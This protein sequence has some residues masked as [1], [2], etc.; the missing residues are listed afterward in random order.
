MPAPGATHYVAPEKYAQMAWVIGLGHADDDA[1]RRE[2]LFARVDGLLDEVGI[3]LSLADAG[4]GR[5]AFDAALPDLARAAFDDPS[6]RTN[7][8]IPLVA[9]LTALLRAGYDGR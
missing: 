1:A 4:V 2:L 8:R 9:E 5:E 7:P 6:L 3:P